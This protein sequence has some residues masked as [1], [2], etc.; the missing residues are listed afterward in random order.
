MREREREIVGG[1]GGGAGRGWEIDSEGKKRESSLTFFYIM[2]EQGGT[3]RRPK[4]DQI[5]RSAALMMWH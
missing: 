5:N 2:H 3:S 1:G 4:P